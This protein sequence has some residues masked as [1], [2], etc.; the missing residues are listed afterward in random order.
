MVRPSVH[1]GKDSKLCN[2][3]GYWGGPPR[4]PTS[5]RA[6]VE[7]L[8]TSSS[9]PSPLLRLSSPA[10]SRPHT[11]AFSLG[12]HASHG[13]YRRFP[14]GCFQLER[15][16]VIGWGL[17]SNTDFL[18]CR[19]LL[20]SHARC[21]WECILKPSCA[22]VA[23]FESVS[24]EAWPL[25]LLDRIVLVLALCL[26][27]SSVMGRLWAPSRFICWSLTLSTSECGCIR[28]QGPCRSS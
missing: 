18:L 15:A 3:V 28:I 12:Q 1:L 11:Q 4:G 9:Q 17:S 2:R 22:P 19:I 8:R 20:P 13:Q 21:S 27:L 7:G 23:A 16:L 6:A 10:K 5:G 26:C 25:M 14:N 24:L